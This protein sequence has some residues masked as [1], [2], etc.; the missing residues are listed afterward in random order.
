MQELPPK[1]KFTLILAIVVVAL[2]F[3]SI[4]MFFYLGDNLVFYI[5]IAVTLI[6]GFYM[7]YS[8]T[9]SEEQTKRKEAGKMRRRG[10]KA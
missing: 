6:L 9:R 5:T 10:R 2:T 8:V 1:E 4:A 3:T 7:T